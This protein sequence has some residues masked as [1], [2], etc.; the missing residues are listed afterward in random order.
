MQDDVASKLRPYARRSL[1]NANKLERSHE[2]SVNKNQTVTCLG[3]MA[4]WTSKNFGSEMCERTVKIYGEEPPKGPTDLLTTIKMSMHKAD[5]RV[6]SGGM[7]F[8]MG[9]KYRNRR[10]RFVEYRNRECWMLKKKMT[11]HSSQ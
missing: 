3:R 1:A 9:K 8:S 10:R 4:V 2:K 7:G 6:S 11:L 5:Q